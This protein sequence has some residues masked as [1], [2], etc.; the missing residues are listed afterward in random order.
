MARRTPTSLAL[1]VLL[2]A[3]FG[4]LATAGGAPFGRKQGIDDPLVDVGAGIPLAPFANLALRFPRSNPGHI[5]KSG[6][7]LAEALRARAIKKKFMCYP[8]RKGPGKKNP[9]LSPGSVISATLSALRSAWIVL[10]KGTD[11]LRD[12]AATSKALSLIVTAHKALIVAAMRGRGQRDGGDEEYSKC[13]DRMDWLSKDFENTPPDRFCVLGKVGEEKA[14]TRVA[15]IDRALRAGWELVESQLVV[16][17][18]LTVKKAN[19]RLVVPPHRGAWR[20]EAEAAVSRNIVLN[21]GV[22]VPRMAYGTGG[23]MMDEWRY[24]ECKDKF[25]FKSLCESKIDATAVANIVRALKVGFRFIDTAALYNNAGL[26]GEAIKQSIASGVLKSAD[27]VRI[28][29]KVGLTAE[30][31][32]AEALKGEGVGEHTRAALQR[33]MREMGV[34][35]LHLAEVHHDEIYSREVNTA[36]RKQLAA[37]VQEGLV[38]ALA[39]KVDEMGLPYKES[40]NFVPQVAQHTMH[41]VFSDF[42]WDGTDTWLTGQRQNITVMGFDLYR[43][44]GLPVVLE[45]LDSLAS[46][47]GLADSYALL[48]AWALRKR[49]IVITLSLSEKH[50]RSSFTEPFKPL[51]PSVFAATD[52]VAW[53]ANWCPPCETSNDGFGIYDGLFRAGGTWEA[54][55]DAGMHRKCA[56]VVVDCVQLDERLSQSTA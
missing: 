46:M 13:V 27:E 50:L 52:S 55:K 10:T 53:L 49:A 44:Q 45:V 11:A 31:P 43:D 16:G 38:L 20:G 56:G 54:L 18:L 51:P 25:L 8:T 22:S 41:A 21:N 26:I 7:N 15:R 40:A 2:A 36:T 28:S 23:A 4:C 12:T 48:Y 1:A 19:L 14:A 42:G 9:C 3:C 30:A 17:Q 33:Q 29:T 5:A 34:S 24:E 47:A 37:M 32:Q 39:D 6:L 35:Q